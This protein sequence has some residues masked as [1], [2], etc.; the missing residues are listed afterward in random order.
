VSDVGSTV[1]VVVT[2]SNAGGSTPAPSAVTATVT[3]EPP[4]PPPPPAAPSNTAL[5]IVNGSA[6]EGQT[7][8]ASTGTWTGSP[9]SYT[10]Q[11]QDCNTSSED[12]SN[13]SGAT[14]LNYKLTAS[15]V[16]HTLRV[17]VT[18]SNAGGS[19]KAS[20]AVTATVAAEPPP[21]P[22]P[23]A[24]PSNTALPIVSGSAMEGETLRT[25]NG[26]WTES[27][28]SY[29]YQWQDCNTSGKGCSNVSGA[30]G[31]SYKLAAKDVGDTIRVVVTA[32]NEGGATA[33]SSAVTAVVT[34]PP[35][36]PPPAPT[37]TALPSVNGSAVEGQTLNAST[38][39]WTG[40]PTSYTYQ[41]QDCNTSGENCSNVSGATS[42]NYK[43]TASDVGHTLRVTVTA[44]NAG[45][46]TKASS[47]A[48]A[49]VAAE[50]PPPPPPPAAPSN[51]ALPI[52]NGSAM[53]GE[54]LRT[55]NG[56]WTES[57]TSYTYQWQD[58]NTSG[59]ACS[60]I[61]KATSSSYKLVSSDVGHTIRAAVTASN[62]GGST[63]A[64]S[65][66]TA[67]VAPVVTEG[68][69][70]Q[71]YV[72]QAGAGSQ[73]GEGSCANA[74]PL[75]WLNNSSDWG[76]GS[77]R[78][79]PGTTVGL[80]G[81]LTAPV[82]VLGNGS[83]GKPV[84]IAFTAGA[85]IAIGGAGCPGTG[86]ID[87][88]DKREYVT[89]DGGSD[90]V[91]ENTNRGAKKEKNESSTTGVYGTSSKHV[92]VENLEIAN[93]YIAEEGESSPIGNTEIRGIFFTEGEPEYLTI[94]NDVVHDTGWAIN[95]TVNGKSNHV[96]IEHNTLY[97][98]SHGISPTG[99]T[100]GGDVGPVVVAYN[101]FYADGVWSSNPGLNHMDGI[102]CYTGNKGTGTKGLHWTGLYIYDNTITMEGEYGVTAPVYI[103][104]ESGPQCGD[105]TSN[106]W[107]FNNVF[108]GRGAGPK[109]ALNNGLLSPY[110][111]EEHIFNNTFIGNKTSEGSCIPIKN[112]SSEAAN[113]AFENNVLTTCRTLIDA[114]TSKLASID[115]NLYAN[116]G[117]ANEA[118]SC[119]GHELYFS[120]FA[121][122]KSCIGGDSH[123]IT[124]GSAKLSA[125]ETF[126]VLGKPEAG[127]EAVGH[128][129]NLTSLC[130]STP[131]EALCKNIDGA[132]RPS[133]G[134]WDI[135][136]F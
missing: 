98:D 10:Y 20:S 48:T 25:S 37:D 122:W 39:T 132:A 23:P 71:I 57:P 74:R 2:A 15:D 79:A 84:T 36:P 77:G 111:G 44:S 124:A 105:P 54:T 5:P 73:S 32:S 125:T 126:G 63:K 51:T 1:R 108:T 116:A 38:G 78:V 101:H 80:C 72:A 22:P 62:A 12:C 4:P 95:V 6:T 70:P 86:C 13:I 130:A 88:G 104:G 127:S 69:G 21:P 76:T 28:T 102:H 96:D 68:E 61:D 135:G 50:P 27:P 45:G 16:G 18:A 92:S 134:G 64:S 56:T 133:T 90:G 67:A 60:N 11:W 131:E 41:W 43:L 53:E 58:C 109:F 34:A 85:K 9:T 17:T 40:S 46:S 100:E 7:L 107:I 26:T 30:T 49:K 129:R 123:S 47:S 97:H 42:L 8:N 31:Q 94:K 112:P 113:I 66:A 65:A 33:A 118:F 82:D 103:E 3:A 110:S 93:L 81:T 59:D 14:S 19:T 29:T 121:E 119:P 83:A 24:A 106:M 117:T 114:E 136:A 35:P 87:L 89:V 55:S 99:S 52:V 128:G 75:S 115:Y 120:Q 91:I